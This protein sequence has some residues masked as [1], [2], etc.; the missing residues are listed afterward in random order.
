MKNNAVMKKLIGSVGALVMACAAAGAQATPL[1][2]LFGGANMFVG[3]QEF[4][5]WTLIDNNG[6][7]A[8]AITLANIEVTPDANDA[9][10][11][12]IIFTASN[13]ALRADDPD[14]LILHF[15]FQV[16]LHDPT[17]RVKD[18]TLRLARFNLAG[19]SSALITI[20]ETVCT[21][22]PNCGNAA[23]P[24][25][26]AFKN[27]FADGSGNQQLVDIQNFAPQESIWVDKFIRVNG[28]SGFAE[29]L[30]FH[31]YFSQESIVATPEPGT[32]ALFALGLIGA[33]FSR[34]R[35]RR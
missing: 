27:V 5:N 11:P 1:S 25:Q 30:E 3:N 2:A 16:T 20:D 13:A 17:M 33:G 6:G 8:G 22:S 9:L 7:G 14:S 10:N 28:S 26:L 31:Q 34:R 4:S 23:N 18:N 35:A 12:G 15:G 32:L 21:T 19:S 24:N 29:L